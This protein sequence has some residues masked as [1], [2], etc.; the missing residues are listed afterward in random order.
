MKELALFAHFDTLALGA[1]GPITTQLG[2]NYF[3]F[4]HP[5]IIPN[6]TFQALYSQFVTDL[7]FNKLAGI[8]FFKTL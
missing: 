4:C 1:G 7:I 6:D 3:S 5:Q 2:V 8:F